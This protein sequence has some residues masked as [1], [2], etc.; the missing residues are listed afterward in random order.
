MV[1]VAG[2]LLFASTIAVGWMDIV[3]LVACNFGWLGRNSQSENYKLSY[4]ASVSGASALALRGTRRQVTIASAA[5]LPSTYAL[6]SRRA[7]VMRQAR[8]STSIRRD[9]KSTRLNSSHG[10]I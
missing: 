9:R 7:A 2:I 4:S 1:H 6:P 5:T 3:K 10:S 8:T